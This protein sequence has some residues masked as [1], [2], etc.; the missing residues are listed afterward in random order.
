MIQVMY[1]YGQVVGYSLICLEY[2]L[3]IS[4]IVNVRVGVL[5][6]RV[7]VVIVQR[8]GVGRVSGIGRLLLIIVVVVVVVVM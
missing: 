7:V 3:G 4:I 6:V 1:V 8:L 5:V 2:V